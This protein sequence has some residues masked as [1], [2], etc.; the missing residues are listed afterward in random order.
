M[1]FKL[2]PTQE[3]PMQYKQCTKMVRVSKQ[4]KFELNFK[5][6]LDTL[7][8]EIPSLYLRKHY[9]PKYRNENVEM[10]KD[11]NLLSLHTLYR[12]TSYNT[13]T[14]GGIHIIW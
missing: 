6:H 4:N 7:I 13:G 11:I 12:F 2:K 8:V 1:P 9:N 14:N 5:V 3:T 10:A